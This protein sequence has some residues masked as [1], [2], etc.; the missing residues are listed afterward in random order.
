MGQEIDR[1]SLQGPVLV[2]ATPIPPIV[3]DENGDIEVYPTVEGAVAGLE[4]V[5]VRAGV[6]EFF[7]SQARLLV[8]EVSGYE[9]SGLRVS[10][11]E[12]LRDELASRL[13]DFVVRV[14]RDRVGLLQPESATLDETL[15]ALLEFFKPDRRR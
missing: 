6:Y 8:A 2:A 4:A 12:P 1:Y 3:V 15:S 5:D 9:V 11:A 13:V 10:N 14:G 7:D